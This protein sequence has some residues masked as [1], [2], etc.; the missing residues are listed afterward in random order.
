MVVVV[1]DSYATLGCDG[2]LDE[3]NEFTKT[4]IGQR[5]I[6]RDTVILVQGMRIVV[7]WQR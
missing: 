2:G 7:I 4:V 1:D 6:L 5:T 3:T